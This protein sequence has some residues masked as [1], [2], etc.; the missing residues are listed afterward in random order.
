M[1]KP[2]LYLIQLTLLIIICSLGACKSTRDL[3]ALQHMPS[4]ELYEAGHKAM[5]KHFY[6]D[7]I[8][9]FE[10][11]DAAYPFG[12]HAKP[13]QLS[14]IYAY[15]K[16]GDQPSA[17]ATA[18]RFIH[19]YP[20]DENVDYAYYMRGL[21]NFNQDRGVFINFFPI[22]ISHRDPGTMREAY[23]DFSVLVKRF[24]KS[25]YTPD[26][27]Q[28][29]IYL[30][31]LFAENELHAARFHLKRGANVAAANR[32]S[33]VIENYSQ[34]PQSAEALRILIAANNALGLE[35]PSQ[36]AQKIKDL[37]QEK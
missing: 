30:R 35:Q 21:A 1:N 31:N 24:P 5:Q 16:M 23:D 8:D 33:F 19:L 37:N 15:F 4:D 32:A 13:A 6:S 3:E 28:R 18:D 22:D 36:N 34:A 10:A 27:N 12:V 25:K 26:A 11:L 20:R 14:L 9:K 29:M 7:A 2:I 17:V